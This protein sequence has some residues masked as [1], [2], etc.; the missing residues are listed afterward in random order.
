M[1]DFL[2]NKHA[3]DYMGTDDD[4]PDSFDAW[5]QNLDVDEWIKLADEYK[6]N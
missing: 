6:K 1:E 4:M 5:L 2:Q 3:E